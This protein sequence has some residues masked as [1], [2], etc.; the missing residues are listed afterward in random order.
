M[1]VCPAI[2]SSFQGHCSGPCKHWGTKMGGKMAIKRS[3]LDTKLVDIGSAARFDVD[4]AQAIVSAGGL[5][6]M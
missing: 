1:A 2:R 3:G 4:T 6:P 5:L